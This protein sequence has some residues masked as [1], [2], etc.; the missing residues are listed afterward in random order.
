MVFL[1]SLCTFTPEIG[2]GQEQNGAGM[3]T[4]YGNNSLRTDTEYVCSSFNPPFPETFCLLISRCL[5][6]PLDIKDERRI[7]WDIRWRALASVGGSR[8]AG[9]PPLLSNLHAEHTLV[10][11][12]DDLSLAELERE[13]LAL[14]VR[15]EDFAV[16]LQ[17]ANVA[18][19]NLLAL[20]S[21]RTAALLLGF[22]D[23][24]RGELLLAG[25]L[26]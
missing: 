23:E 3:V 15:V 19:A 17:L 22:N 13:G 7:T 18:H 11:S 24:A 6:R 10:P 14:C 20:L 8:W 2:R 21:G 25:N 12:L 16:G 4:P 1:G 5:L 26:K 9:Q